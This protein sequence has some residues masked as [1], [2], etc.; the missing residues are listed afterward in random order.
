V[1]HQEARQ[2]YSHGVRMFYKEIPDLTIADEA[3]IEPPR[4]VV[5][6]AG[7]SKFAKPI[8]IPQLSLA[9]NFVGRKA[10]I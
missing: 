10:C 4:I 3:E 8:Q 6:P 1:T 7:I 5:L 9:F 2:I